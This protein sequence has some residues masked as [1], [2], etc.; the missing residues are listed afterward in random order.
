MAAS[1]LAIANTNP[2]MD[3]DPTGYSADNTLQGLQTGIVGEAALAVG[4]SIV[5][6]A[7]RVLGSKILS[8]LLID[9]GAGI[10]IGTLT[11]MWI[12][13]CVDVAS[14][15]I[16]S[17]TIVADTVDIV[18]DDSLPDEIADERDKP[19]D[20]PTL[21]YRWG[22]GTYKNLTP[23]PGKDTTGISYSLVPPIDGSKY[24]TTTIESINATGVLLAVQ[25]SPNHVSVFPVDMSTMDE[26]MDSRVNADS[27]P[28]PYSVLLRSIS[29]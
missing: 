19:D 14:G 17:T 7:A 9:V 6:T 4:H 12:T 26:W 23:R 29:W 1:L 13:A 21:I 28:R 8:S 16:T 3:S 24:T 18:I 25:D 11:S 5:S 15:V 2:V 22:S 27:N 20:N 10:L